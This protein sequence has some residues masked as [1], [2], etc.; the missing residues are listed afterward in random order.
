MIIQL[1]QRWK[2]ES[3]VFSG[4]MLFRQT[5]KPINKTQRRQ[6]VIAFGK[7]FFNLLNHSL[8]PE[9]TILIL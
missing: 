7:L 5:H 1:C 4:L 8:V 2:E 9:E 6:T 3:D